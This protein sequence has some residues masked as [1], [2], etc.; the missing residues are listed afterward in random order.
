MAQSGEIINVM[1]SI[2]ILLIILVLF[3]MIITRNR[4]STVTKA[5]LE[6][7]I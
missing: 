5:N 3:I 7:H 2:V 1:I 4:K 6:L